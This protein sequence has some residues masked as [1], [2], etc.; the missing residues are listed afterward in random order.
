MKTF[1]SIALIILT[2]PV[3]AQEID[4]RYFELRTYHCHENKRPD[5]IK[6]FKNHTMKLFGKHGIANI[7]YFL[8]VNKD[9]NSLVYIIAYPNKSSRDSLWNSFASDP[10]W[11]RVAKKSEE[12]GP[13]V[14]KVDQVF[15]TIT[16]ELS[17]SIKHGKYGKR[18]F[19]LRTYYCFPGKLGNLR[20]RFEDH[21][22]TLFEK[23]GM[24]NV[25]YW[26]SDE[27]DNS[28]SKLVY[29]LGHKSEQEGLASFKAFRA[30]PEWQKVSKKSE[31]NGKI[32]EKVISVYLEP[33][34]FS[35]LK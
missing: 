23:F 10:E 18:V 24:S 12:N 27:K 2:L 13:L 32:V 5:L 31:E 21:T 14:E 34:P 3:A 7:A 33:L 20:T 28:Q 29:L 9:D 16:P 26:T 22:R 15:M 25:V 17:P 35:P 8:P 19:E 11:Q 6:R 4:N 30:D 1:I